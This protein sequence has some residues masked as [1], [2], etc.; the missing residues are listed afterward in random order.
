MQLKVDMFKEKRIIKVRL[1]W[2][3]H[4]LE[5]EKVKVKRKDVG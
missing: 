4:I 1:R 3:S 2:K 5:K